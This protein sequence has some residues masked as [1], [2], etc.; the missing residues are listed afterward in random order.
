[1]QRTSG[2]ACTYTRPPGPP[3]KKGERLSPPPPPQ[4]SSWDPLTNGDSI[5][6]PHKPLTYESRTLMPASI[7]T[8]NGTPDTP[9][10]PGP[11]GLANIR[12]GIQ[13]YTQGTGSRSQERTF[14]PQAAGGGRQPCIYHPSGVVSVSWLLDM[15]QCPLGHSCCWWSA[16]V[17]RLSGGIRFTFLIADA[18]N[19]VCCADAEPLQ[20]P[21][22]RG[23][24]RSTF[25]IQGPA[26]LG[27]A[28]LHTL[29]VQLPA[30]CFG[31]P[32]DTRN[33]VHQDQC[34]GAA[35]QSFWNTIGGRFSR[36]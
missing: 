12:F 5:A 10:S 17:P 14:L 2:F 21:C 24:Q 4:Q 29:E 7:V 33:D 35:G 9:S 32:P 22:R 31:P 28:P 15:V 27:I 30:A 18:L 3:A 23:L 11:V 20:P 34:T 36:D 13:P 19:G 1:M 25:N 8:P 6:S 26:Q 16:A